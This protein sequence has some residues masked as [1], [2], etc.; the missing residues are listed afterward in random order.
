MILSCF[1][2]VIWSWRR[3]SSNLRHSRSLILDR[4]QHSAQEKGEDKGV[5]DPI[6][7]SA[8]DEGII[9]NYIHVARSQYLKQNLHRSLSL[10]EVP[11]DILYIIC[12]FEN[13]IQ[14]I[15]SNFY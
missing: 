10:S 7:I 5:S 11:D 2:L 14:F 4:S 13:L 12:L 1:R 6:R 8:R 3:R 9:A 15:Q